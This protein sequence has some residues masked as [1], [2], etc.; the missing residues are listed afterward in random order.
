MLQ[1]SE[2]NSASDSLSTN[3]SV[4]GAVAVNVS[5][6]APAL[7]L[8]DTKSIYCFFSAAVNVP[9]IRCCCCGQPSV[10]Q[11]YKYFSL[12][13]QLIGFGFHSTTGVQGACGMWQLQSIE[14]F[15]HP[16]AQLLFG[17]NVLFG[18]HVSLCNEK[19]IV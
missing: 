11:H 19:L 5:V 4:A 18:F 14:L 12:L 3:V 15:K 2:Y 1:H 6:S 16:K 10:G 13:L 8:K 17:P 9:S 7:V